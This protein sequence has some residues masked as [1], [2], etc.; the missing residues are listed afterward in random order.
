MGGE[1]L[2]DFPAGAMQGIFVFDEDVAHAFSLR[3]LSS[4]ILYRLYCALLL[5]LGRCTT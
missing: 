1:S 4:L 3:G 5:S 2:V